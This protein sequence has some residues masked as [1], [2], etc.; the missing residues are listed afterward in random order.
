V[1]TSCFSGYVLNGPICNAIASS[2]SSSGNPISTA[3]VADGYYLVNGVP[4]V[5]SIG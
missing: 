3:P 5:C 4:T 2:V 1:A